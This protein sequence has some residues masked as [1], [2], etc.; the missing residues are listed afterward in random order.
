MRGGGSPHAYCVS[1]QSRRLLTEDLPEPSIS[2]EIATK[3]ARFHD[4]VMPFNK[5][6]RWLFGTMER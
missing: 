1:P 4:M 5:E 2:G 3:M 6:P